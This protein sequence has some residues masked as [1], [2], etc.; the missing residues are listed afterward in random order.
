MVITIYSIKGN[1]QT[2]LYACLAEAFRTTSS[3]YTEKLE[4][5]PELYDTN[6]VP[7]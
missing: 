1:I 4:I 3:I 2:S 5:D 7:T 6:R